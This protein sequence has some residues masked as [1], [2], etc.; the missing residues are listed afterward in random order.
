KKKKNISFSSS[1]F[2]L[3]RTAKRFSRQTQTPWTSGN[4]FSSPPLES[5]AVP[6]VICLTIFL[7]LIVFSAAADAIVDGDDVIEVV[8]EDG[9]DSSVLKIELEKLNSKIRELEVLIDEKAREL[10]KKDYLISQKDEIFRDKSDRVSFL[11]SEIESLQREGKLHAEETTAEAHSRAGELEKQVNELKKELDA[12]NREKNALEVRSNEAQKKMDK[13]ISKLEKLQNTNEEQKSKIQKLQRALKVAEE[14]MIK[15]KFEVTSKTEKLMEE[16]SS[17]KASSRTNLLKKPCYVQVHEERRGLNEGVGGIL[18]KQERLRRWMRIERWEQEESGSGSLWVVGGEGRGKRLKRDLE[19][20]K[21]E[22]NGEGGRWGVKVHGAWLPPWLASF[23]DEH[24][25]PTINTVVQKVREGKMRVENW[26]GPRVE[27]IKSK[28]IP[29]MHKQLLVVKTNSEPHL[30]LLCKRSSEAYKASKQAL[31]PHLIGAQEFAYPYFQKVKMV[32]KP[33]VDR[34][35]IIM[36]PHVDK[37]QVALSPYTKDVVHAC[38]NFM[39]SAT[40]HRQKVKSTIQE[41]LNRHDITRPA[42][43][44]E[45]EWLLDS[46]LLVLPVLILFHLCSCCGIFR[47]KAR[48]SVR[49]TNTNHG[50]RK[51]KKGT[52]GRWTAHLWLP[53]SSRNWNGKVHAMIHVHKSVARSIGIVVDLRSIGSLGSDRTC[54]NGRS[55]ILTNCHCCCHWW[56]RHRHLSQNWLRYTSSKVQVQP[57]YCKATSC[58]WIVKLGL[59]R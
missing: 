4:S 6:K 22:G 32:S 20:V 36:K 43:S 24:A 26:L 39:Q 25:K 28:W 34:V 48:T 57:R 27:P 1:F 40:T 16:K 30:Q 52:S 29:A 8:R 35:A 46:A 19:L 53:K 12:Q 59:H 42:A 11:E 56:R 47:K 2:V 44:T 3:L 41:V 14:E 13:I 54:H 38:G 51:A 23:W 58:I 45:F 21:N 49:G 50:R 37:V 7:S 9:S 31:I 17:L 33:Y 10:E 15:A 5:M 55:N 18:D